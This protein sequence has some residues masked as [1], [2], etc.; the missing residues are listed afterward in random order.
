LKSPVDRTV[1]IH[2]NNDPGSEGI[3]HVLE[4][5]S[6]NPRLLI[7]EDVQ[8]SLFLGL[9]RDAAVM[10]GNSS[11]GIIEAGSFKTP[12]I[13]I[14]P[15]QSGRE[16]GPNV[17]HIEYGERNVQN[18]LN[19]LWDGRAFRRPRSGNV[20]GGTGAGAKIASALAKI[21]IDARLR[22]KLIAY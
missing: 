3:R 4:E 10:V 12:V 7:R 14:G 1:I 13:D 11:S 15:R 16:R 21:K 5:Y 19:A 9:M 2:P 8:R 18:A 22:R 20:Y 17:T 6:D